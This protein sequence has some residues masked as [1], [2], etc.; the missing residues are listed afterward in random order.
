MLSIVEPRLAQAGGEDR[1]TDR[2]LGVESAGH[3]GRRCEG[4]EEARQA[5][6]FRGDHG[7]TLGE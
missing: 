1:R 6:T 5:V 2:L 3:I 7:V 4:T